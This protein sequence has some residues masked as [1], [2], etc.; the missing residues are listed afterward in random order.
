MYRN[1]TAL[2]VMCKLFEGIPSAKI[3]E[4]FTHLAVREV[5]L[6]K[7]EVLFKSGTRITDF[8]VI[9]S[10]RLSI[11]S[12]D[13]DGHRKILE[14]FESMDTV[15]IS[16]AVADIK[17]VAVSVEA[18]LDSEVILFNA[19]KVLNPGGKPSE[20]H[21]RL[22]Q[23]ITRELARKTVLLGR[24]MRIISSR[25]T[26]ERIMKYL[27]EESVRRGSK[28]FEIPYDRQ[29]LADY[30]CVERSALSAEISKLIGRGVIESRKNHFKLL[31]AAS[32]KVCYNFH[33]TQTQ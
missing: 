21:I 16:L 31:F 32:D 17:S 27:I 7:G 33:N 10:G 18:R 30:L 28:E 26:S 13:A 25:A 14:L 3:N 23:N 12:Y 15:A 29:A 19:N 1:F 22:L 11:S 20:E 24:K 4:L 8:A 2:P 9:I 5:T 6:K